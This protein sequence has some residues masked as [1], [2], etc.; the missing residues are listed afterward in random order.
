MPEPRY[1]HPNH[2]EV[3]AEIIDDEVIII[4]LTDG[5]YYSMEGVGVLVW[6]LLEAA[7]SLDDIVQAIS[8]TY[9]V[10][11]DRAGDDAKELIESLK[12]ERLVVAGV[13]AQTQTTGSGESH[14]RPAGLQYAKPALHVYE[15]MNDLLALDP[16]APGH[17]RFDSS[18]VPD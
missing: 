4:R 1:L 10:D 6:R 8:E 3:A 2:A 14:D 17:R 12:R 7:R 13:G 9:A 5:V 11:A 16:P 15:D 18:D